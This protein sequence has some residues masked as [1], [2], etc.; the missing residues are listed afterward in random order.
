MRTALALT[1]HFGEIDEFKGL[2]TF[3]REDERSKWI[4]DSH[5]SSSSILTVSH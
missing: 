3:L 1:K 2:V 4:P 5:K